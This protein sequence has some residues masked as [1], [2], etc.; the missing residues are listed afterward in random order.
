M[1]ALPVA[2]VT[3]MTSAVMAMAR[4]EGRG[5][6]AGMVTRP[7][8]AVLAIRITPAVKRRSE[9]ARLADLCGKDSA[10]RH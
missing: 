10:V 5:M 7:R 1:R 6:G 4:F 2:A 9:H 3:P 8:P